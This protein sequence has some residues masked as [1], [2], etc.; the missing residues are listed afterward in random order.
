MEGYSEGALLI[1]RGTGGRISFEPGSHIPDTLPALI[2]WTSR[3]AFLTFS[4]GCN[5]TSPP[6]K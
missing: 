5:T 4:Q 1:K 2:Y 6:C 3:P